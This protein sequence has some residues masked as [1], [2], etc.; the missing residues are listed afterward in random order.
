MIEDIEIFHNSNDL[1]TKEFFGEHLVSLARP[2]EGTACTI[3]VDHQVKQVKRPK[4][5][6]EQMIKLRE[7][8]NIAIEHNPFLSAGM[9]TRKKM[10]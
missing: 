5:K 9:E 3:T 7:Q 8:L 6:L 10:G 1:L 4:K 2:P